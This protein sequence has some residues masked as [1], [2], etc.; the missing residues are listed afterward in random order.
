MQQV[1]TPKLYLE[2]EAE[3]DEEAKAY[4]LG[5]S[6]GSLPQDAL[7]WGALLWS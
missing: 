4:M 1:S 2:E 7:Y 3:L 6:V 5:S